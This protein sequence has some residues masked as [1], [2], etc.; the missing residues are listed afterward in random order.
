MGV[1]GLAVLLTIGLL[2]APL[3]GEAQPGAKAHRIGILEASPSSARAD[4]WEAFR[5]GLVELG[6]VEGRNIA[7]ERR[8]A[9]GQWAR[10]P[11]LAAELVRLK[12][13]VIVAAPT[14]AIRAVQQA[15]RT[16][17]I[18][19]AISGDPVGTGF[20]VSLARPAGNI[21]GL[22]LMTS[23]LVGKQLALLKEVV[24]NVSRVA[25]LWNPANPLGAPQ[26][27]EA[28]V[29]AQAL[30]TQLQV[31]EVRA[32]TEFDGAFTAMTRARAGALL[33]L[34]DAIFG[35]NRSLFA[36]LAAKSRVPAMY[37][38]REF[39]EV[40][41]LMAYGPRY[42]D[43]FRRAATYVDK[44]LKGAKPADLPVE[45][46]TKFELV[47]NLKTAKALGLTI[48]QSVLLRADQII[49]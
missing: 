9:D 1:I 5:Q 40:G 20:I 2:A 36:D 24:P 27:K 8:F 26:L 6:Y 46:P 45:Q 12:V 16:I 29:A 33:V 28:K 42:A 43:L 22:S 15:T 30:A 18:V 48:P 35:V 25:V 37:G 4:L 13:E 31:L 19:M 41:G 7:I 32:S 21:T 39:V 38:L 3:A 34:P 10:L 49:E 14:P 23:D 47:I 44:I 11:D 17:P